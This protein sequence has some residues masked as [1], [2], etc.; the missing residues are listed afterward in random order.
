MGVC[1]D[2]LTTIMGRKNRATTRYDENNSRYM[3]Y[4]ELDL[5][6]LDLWTLIYLPL[7]FVTIRKLNS[8]H[9]HHG[10]QEYTAIE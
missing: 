7:N 10:P 4:S 6:E 1:A 9:P 5:A 2:S 8:L 3:F